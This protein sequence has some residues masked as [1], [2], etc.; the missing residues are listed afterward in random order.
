VLAP[1]E[2]ASVVEIEC[3]IYRPIEIWTM[4]TAIEKVTGPLRSSSSI[5]TSR[6]GR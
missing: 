1:G 2:P 5:G 3:E 6:A 4:A